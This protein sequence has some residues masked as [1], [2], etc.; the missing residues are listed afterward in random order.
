[1]VCKSRL[2]AQCLQTWVVDINNSTS[3]LQSIKRDTI[4]QISKSH[5]KDKVCRR[6]GHLHQYRSV[7]DFLWRFHACTRRAMARLVQGLLLKK[8]SYHQA[9][10]HLHGSR[11][12][13]ESPTGEPITVSSATLQP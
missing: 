9:Y 12:D 6:H 11:L 8:F 7:K 10:W 4:C 3:Q 1:M 13:R 5:L 2:E